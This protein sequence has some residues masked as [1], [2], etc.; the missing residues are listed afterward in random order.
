M[1]NLEDKYKHINGWGIDA[2]PENEPTYPMK[3]WTGDD[4]NRL[5]YERPPLQPLDREF[6]KS[7]ER[8]SHSAVFGTSVTPSGLSGQLRRHAFKY[9]EGEWRHWLTLV[10]A[11][12]VN[13]LEGIADDIAHGH[14]P[15]VFAERGWGAEW[16]HN[17]KSMATKLAV[18]AAVTAGLVAFVVFNTKKKRKKAKLA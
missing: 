17:K 4:H 3:K 13:V 8:P 12:R 9:S 5:N 1:E 7:N 16:E 11:D 14:V 18:T 10:L 2:D 6:L 15:N